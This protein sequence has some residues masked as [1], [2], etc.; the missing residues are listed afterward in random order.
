MRCCAT[1]IVQLSRMVYRTK[2]QRSFKMLYQSVI[3][4]HRVLH[5]SLNGRTSVISIISGRL[6]AGMSSVTISRHRDLYWSRLIFDSG[7]RYCM[8]QTLEFFIPIVVM[9]NW[10]RVS[11]QKLIVFSFTSRHPSSCP[12]SRHRWK[13]V[14]SH[15]QQQRSHAGRASSLQSQRS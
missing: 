2:K 13:S 12:R 14:R 15:Q 11:S 9:S 6:L 1:I 3:L 4:G 10:Q 5:M 7:S 8:L